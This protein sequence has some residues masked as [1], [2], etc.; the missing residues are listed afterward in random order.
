MRD[1]ETLAEILLKAF[2]F[3]A[4][5]H[6][7]AASEGFKYKGIY[8]VAERRLAEELKRRRIDAQVFSSVDKLRGLRGPFCFD[9]HLLEILALKDAAYIQK[10]EQKVKS[11]EKD[12][13]ELMKYKNDEIRE[14]LK[15]ERLIEA[16]RDKRTIEALRAKIK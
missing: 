4:V 6:T 11:L 2:S 12:I 9:H 13:V 3:R 5:G 1:H 14:K 10:L 8:L 15:D 16:L 7:Y